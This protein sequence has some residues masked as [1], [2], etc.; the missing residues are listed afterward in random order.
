MV[1]HC[2]DSG[3]RL[4]LRLKGEGLETEMHG[5]RLL[6]S[7]AFALRAPFT[8]SHLLGRHRGSEQEFHL[9]L[10]SLSS[11][12]PNSPSVN[13]KPEGECELYFLKIVIKFASNE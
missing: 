9:L 4:L 2:R 12:D 1:G 7:W 6:Q 11:D 5:G 8:C 10:S 13:R 3:L